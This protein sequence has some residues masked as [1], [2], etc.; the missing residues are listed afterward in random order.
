[1]QEEF[2]DKHPSR[3]YFESLTQVEQVKAMQIVA[4]F[5]GKP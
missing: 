1:M 3:A 2:T 5:Q 4:Q